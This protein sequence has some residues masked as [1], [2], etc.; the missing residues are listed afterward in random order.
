M[1]TE[2]VKIYKFDELDDS[3]KERA[4]AWYRGCG[5]VYSWGD[6]S[7][8]SLK[9]FAEWFGIRIR[10]YSLGGSD[11]R[12][13]G[14]KFDL[15]VDDWL[16]DEYDETHGMRGVRLWKYLNNQ[17]MLPDLS[18]NCPFTGYCMDEVLLDAVRE[19][20]E[21]PHDVNY[22]ELMTECIDRFVKEYAAEVDY[23][24]SDEAV[25]ENILANEYE[26]TED[27]EHWG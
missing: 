2:Q 20:M 12:S 18:G 4:R 11:N 19:F 24:Y 27:G 5:D 10:D 16:A 3:A 8:E 22:T 6:E 9:K 25:D 23:E 17:F 21:R 13:Q 1:R 26:F 14:V 7:V 15:N